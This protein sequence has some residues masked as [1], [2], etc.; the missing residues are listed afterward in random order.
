MSHSIG[1][2]DHCHRGIRGLRHAKLAATDVKPIAG[3]GL[4]LTDHAAQVGVDAP[5]QINQCFPLILAKAGQQPALA[6]QRRDDDLVVDP[7]SLGRQRNRVAAAVARVGLDGYQA[8]VL[9]RGQGAADRA[10][11]ESDDVTD[12]RGGNAGLDDEQRHD[13]PFRDVDAEIALIEHRRAVRQLVGDEGDERRNVAVE[14]EQRAVVGAHGLRRTRPA[15]LSGK[16][17]L[18][19]VSI[20][21]AERRASNREMGQGF[22]RTNAGRCG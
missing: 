15:R 11:V 14:I 16:G 8:A 1:E 12:A 2:R 7:A 21:A 22:T 20:I 13:P 5:E 17:I 18:A 3:S 4:D 6:F 19:H 9:H 10:L